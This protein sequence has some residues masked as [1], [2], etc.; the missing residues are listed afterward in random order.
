[1]QYTHTRLE[2]KK[3]VLTFQTCAI[4]DG[5]AYAMQERLTK[6]DCILYSIFVALTAVAAALSPYDHCTHHMTQALTASLR[7]PDTF[8]DTAHVWMYLESAFV[9]SLFRPVTPDSMAPPAMMD[10]SNVLLG[11]VLLHQRRLSGNIGNED[12]KRLCHQFKLLQDYAT[13]LN[14]YWPSSATRNG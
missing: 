12:I 14:V 1:P 3:R 10:G 8:P 13:L 11:N 7:L 4:Q 5:H 6:G 2:I 9:S